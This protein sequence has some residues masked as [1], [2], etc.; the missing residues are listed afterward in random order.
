MTDAAVPFAP[1]CPCPLDG[2]RVLDLSRLVCGNMLTLQL[3]DFGAEVIKLEPPEGDPLRHWREEG[4]SV[5]WKVYGRNKKSVRFDLRTEYG[6][7]LLQRLLQTAHVLVES[8]RPGVMEA[9]G[10]SPDRLLALNSKLVIVR[11]SGFGQ[12]GP[13]SPRPGFGSLVEGMCGF[14]AKNGF[15]DKPPALPNM[16]LADMVAGIQ[17]AFATMVALREAEREGGHGQV[18]DLSLLEPLH[19]TLGPDAAVHRLTGR[20]PLRS[21]N[22]VSLTAPR[23]VYATVDGAWLALS[24]STQGMTARLFRTLNR[25]DLI[26]DPR[27]R[28]NADRLRHVE[29]LDAIVQDFVGQRTLDSNLAFF[30]AAQVTVGPVYDAAGFGDDPHVQA[31]GVLVEMEDV[32]LG[33]LP[34]HAVCPRLSHTPGALR[35][36]APELGQHD[37][38]VLISLLM[39]ETQ[40]C[41]QGC[42][43]SSHNPAVPVSYCDGD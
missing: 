26:D 35:R 25:P 18:V 7:S 38:E 40:K 36:P 29:E 13:Y 16:A 41:S 43:I 32:E 11:I 1:D 24:A 22:R 15:A 10:F 9:A 19:M 30:A 39:E 42:L 34:M 8:F 4:V 6:K 31:R 27:F 12:T 33:S 2:V 37:E 23:N 14:A 28:T 17:G 5:H 20:S 3:A 21:G